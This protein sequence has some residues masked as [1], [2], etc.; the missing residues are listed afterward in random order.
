MAGFRFRRLRE[1]RELEVRDAAP[2]KRAAS[3]LFAADERIRAAA[4]ELAFA[5]AE[6]GADATAPLGEALVAARVRLNEAFRLNRRNGDAVPGTAD[7]VRTRAARVVELCAEVEEVLDQQAAALADRVARVRRAPEVFAGVRADA[8]RLRVR[9][10]HARDTIGRL[11]VRYAREALAPVAANPAEAE[12]LIGFAEHSL[13]VAV[14]R[15]AAGQFE[16]A[17]VALEASAASVRS[18][19]TLLD[20]VDDFEVELLRAEAALATTVEG[21][22]RELAAAP[23]EPHARRVAEAIAELQAAL[24]DLPGAGVNTDPFAHLNRVREARA[25]LDAALASVRERASRP[26]QPVRPVRGA[27]HMHHAIEDADH[28]LD[29]A[30]DAIAGHPGWIGAEA[31]ARLAESERTRIDLAHCLGSPTETVAAIDAD[32][33][34]RLLAMA[35]RVASLASEAVQLARRDIDAFRSQSRLPAAS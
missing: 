9:I 32:H 28:R 4:E 6:L 35:Q 25:A 15:R 7:E 18:A 34:A 10:P 30:R 20:A 17:S 27:H 33:G 29:A 11:A 24:A 14:R 2:A 3:A 21:A 13:G 23:V 12:Q 31:L 8:E 19:A 1:A 16:P 5:E 22:R 26:T